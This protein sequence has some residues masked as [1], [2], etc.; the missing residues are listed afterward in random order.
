MKNE[1]FT[2]GFAKCK[3]CGK[4]VNAEE[5]YA[6]SFIKGENTIWVCNCGEIIG[7][8]HG[9]SKGRSFIE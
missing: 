3:W 6:D 4:I 2:D 9:Y 8:K 7:G 1:E 5:C